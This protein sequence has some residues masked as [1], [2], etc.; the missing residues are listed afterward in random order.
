MNRSICEHTIR[1]YGDHPLAEKIAAL[2]IEV[3]SLRQSRDDFERQLLDASRHIERLK[4]R[5]A[6]MESR[7]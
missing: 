1:A 6:E 3:A 5:I 4:R 7:A 2:R